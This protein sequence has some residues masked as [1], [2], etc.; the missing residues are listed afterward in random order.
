MAGSMNVLYRSTIGKKVLMAI[1][2]IIGYGFVIGH[3]VGNLKVFLGRDVFNE[4]ALFLRTVGE[5]L[6]P[7]SVLLWV[8][9]IILL[10]ALVVHVTMAIQLS[11][12]DLA[13]R[14]VHYVQKRPVQASFASLTLRWGGT[15]IFLFLIYHLM[16]LTWGW[17][18]PGFS[19]D[20]AYH[21]VV[22]GF[23][24]PIVVLFYLLAMAALALHMFHGVWS[25]FQTLGLNGPRT[26]SLWR[27]LAVLSAVALFL[28]FSIVPVA[29]LLGLVR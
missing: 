6:L 7:Y 27:G 13:G 8:A 26:N 24:N 1:S 22:A 2:G 5:P 28:G 3:M 25:M 10:A 4:Y 21:N 23:Q 15:A 14:P 11:R 16:H 19:H 9:R 12:I 29:V 20:D 18:N 17:V